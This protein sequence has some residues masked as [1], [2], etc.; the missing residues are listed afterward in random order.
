M[1]AFL[2]RACTVRYRAKIRPG[3]ALGLGF[4]GEVPA[5]FGRACRLPRD[6]APLEGTLTATLVWG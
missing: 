1:I 5:F 2:G 6:M 3:L 4:K